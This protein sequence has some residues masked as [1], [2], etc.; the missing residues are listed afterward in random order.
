MSGYNPIPYVNRV[1]PESIV[2]ALNF[3]IREINANFGAI[4]FFNTGSVTRRQLFSALA[5]ANLMPTVVNGIPA[6]TNNA[7]YI[8]FISANVVSMGDTLAANV[9]AT[10]GYTNA[11]M[12]A[13]FATAAG[14]TP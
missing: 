12:A 5:A 1:Q 14:L 7:V 4:G 13:L 8:E 3:L 11:Q 10:L 9:Q 2:N 6:D